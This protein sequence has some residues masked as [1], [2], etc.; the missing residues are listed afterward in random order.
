LPNEMLT[1]NKLIEAIGQRESSGRFDA[2]SDGGAVGLLGIMPEDAMEGFRRGVPTVWDVASGLGFEP[3]DKSKESAIAL[4]KDPEVNM[5]IAVPYL[6][7]LMN[8]YNGNTQDVLTAYNAGPEKYDRAGLDPS[9]LDKAEQK[10]YA[11]DV[12]KDYF[13]IFGEELPENLGVLTS[14]RP[15]SRPKGL[16]Q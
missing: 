9:R 5:G 7:E 14:P 11:K 15:K 12:S 1:L 3:V 8:K 6:T 10:T 4:L 2:I 13:D 16:L